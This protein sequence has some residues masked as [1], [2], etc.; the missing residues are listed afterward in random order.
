MQK[1]HEKFLSL[2]DDLS[3]EDLFGRKEN[4]LKYRK[5]VD[6]FFRFLFEI[7]TEFEWEK[8]FERQERLSDIDTETETF[9][10]YVGPRRIEVVA[11][12]D[13]K[14]DL[15]EV[16]NIKIFVKDTAINT[17]FKICCTYVFTH[18][19]YVPRISNSIVSR[20]RFSFLKI[21]DILKKNTKAQ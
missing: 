15:T 18:I 11:Q 8:K 12:K 1:R 16:L 2:L 10:T 19:S 5:R 20:Y 6:D 9:Y 21:Y 7:A 13:I 17:L 3:D 4:F 14:P